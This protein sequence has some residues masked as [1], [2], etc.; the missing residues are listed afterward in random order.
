MT[1]VNQVKI[2]IMSD[3]K[4]MK[5]YYTSVLFLLVSSNVVNAGFMVLDHPVHGLGSITRDLDLGLDFLDVNLSADLTMDYVL[6]QFGVGGDFEGFRYA[7]VGE[8]LSLT[9]R[10]FEPDPRL[11]HPVQADQA[12]PEWGELILALGP[13]RPEFDRNEIAGVTGSRFRNFTNFH[14]G[15]A[16]DYFGGPPSASDHQAIDSLSTGGAVG[17]SISSPGMGHWLVAVP[18]P[19]SRGFF[20]CFVPVIAAL[21]K[22]ATRDLVR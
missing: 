15:A 5:S 18:E 17:S 3:W 10:V 9:T 6:T 21:R 16:R 12:D 8:F 11:G 1:R 22:R 2:I 19:A 14:I 20:A 13:T 7:T 4:P